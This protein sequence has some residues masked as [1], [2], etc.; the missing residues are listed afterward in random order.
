MAPS[1]VGLNLQPMSEP[2]FGGRL[3]AVVV[4]IRAGIQLRHRSESR[5]GRSVI[6]ERRKATLT[7]CLITVHLSRVGLVH[8]ARANI[9]SPQIDRVADLVFQSEAP[10]HEIGHMQLSIRHSR[11]RHWLQTG[12]SIR[13]WRC[14]G[15]L[16]S[17]EAR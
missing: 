1:V 17:G 4:A 13:E 7:R 16:A 5:I 14:T 9:L 8:R 6:R 3:K 10:L 2:L 11:N 12:T 15:E